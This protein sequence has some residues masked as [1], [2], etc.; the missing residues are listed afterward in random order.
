VATHLIS[1]ERRSI[2]HGD[3]GPGHFS[4][5]A[6]MQQGHQALQPGVARW[7]QVFTARIS[8]SGEKKATMLKMEFH[9]IV[10]IFKL[11]GTN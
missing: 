6:A 10:F 2:S 11:I 1:G 9:S 4:G 5:I 3:E 7:S 8:R